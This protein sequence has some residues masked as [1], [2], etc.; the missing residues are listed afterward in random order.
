MVNEVE[1]KC[2]PKKSM[3]SWLVI[4]DM[5]REGEKIENEVVGK[6]TG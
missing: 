6:N 1:S 5:T 3:W 2:Y 4:W